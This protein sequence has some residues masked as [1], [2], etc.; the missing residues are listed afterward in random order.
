MASNKESDL[1][2]LPIESSNQIKIRYR[3]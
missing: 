2:Y 3:G 1:N